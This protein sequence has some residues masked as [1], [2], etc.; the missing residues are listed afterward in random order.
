MQ[1]LKKV[2]HTLQKRKLTIAAAE[3]CTGGYLSYLL[4]KIPGSSKVFKGSI[5]AYSLESKNKFFK[6]SSSLLK[7][8]QGVSEE[9]SLI[10]AKKVKKIF[11]TSIGISVVGFAGP[12]TKKGIKVGTIFMSIA[13][14]KGTETKKLIIKGNRDTIR[15]KASQYL[16]KL[17][18]E[19]IK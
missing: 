7:R 6:I 16:I 11:R 15:K 1:K 2:I 10:L 9:I 12:K 3:S 4:T 13:D 18:H 14:K 8:T 5:I 19:R 17:I